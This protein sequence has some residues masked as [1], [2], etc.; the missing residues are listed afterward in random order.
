MQDR[1]QHVIQS[2]ATGFAIIVTDEAN[3]QSSIREWS[4]F[5]AEG[6]VQIRKWHAL[7]ICPPP[8]GTC[9]LRLCP[10]WILQIL[11]I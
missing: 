4:L 10:P 3:I 9:A 8:R 6:A 2:S 5:M 1:D 7:K 11:E